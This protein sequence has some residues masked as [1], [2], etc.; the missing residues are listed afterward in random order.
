MR[1]TF[2]FGDGEICNEANA[3]TFKGALTI[4]MKNLDVLFEDDLIDYQDG[5]YLTTDG[6]G[7]K[8]DRWLLDIRKVNRL[9]C[10]RRGGVYVPEELY[11]SYMKWYFNMWV[12]S[13][14][15][16]EII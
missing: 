14:Q 9:T 4:A 6:S 12:L 16:I 2:V 7:W 11:L 8:H 10:E 3:D 13:G 5:K 1:I 15:I